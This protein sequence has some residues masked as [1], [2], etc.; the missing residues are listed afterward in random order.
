M[1]DKIYMARKIT[2]SGTQGWTVPYT[3]V[4]LHKTGPRTY[5]Q[6]QFIVCKP[7]PN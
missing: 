1:P 2:R 6:G 5:C 7:I 3:T 4:L